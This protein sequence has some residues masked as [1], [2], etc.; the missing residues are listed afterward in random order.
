MQFKSLARWTCALLVAV[1]APAMAQQIPITDFAKRSEAWGATLSPTGEYAAIEVPTADGQETQLQIV[2]LDGSGKTQVL[3][4]GK[5][6]HVSD[7]TWT[8]DDRVVVARAKLEPLMARPYSTGQLMT[9]DINGK[10]QD[11]LFGYVPDAGLVRG[12]RK[13]E[14]WADVIKVLD[15]QPGMALVDFTCATCGKEPDTVIFRVDTRTGERKEVER[16]DKLAWYQFDR[17]GEARIRRTLDDNDEPV[18]SYRRT[19]GAAW[20]PMPKS[21]AGR[22][23]WNSRWEADNNTLYA[24]VTDGL[25]PEQ[26][27]RIDLAAGTRTKLAGRPDAEVANWMIEGR[28]GVPFAVYFNTDKPSIQY[29]KMDSE[30]AKLH[31]GLMKSFPG[32]IVWFNDVSRDGNKVLF[33]VSSDR[34]PGDWYLYDRA[35]KK[36]Q[37]LVEFRPW[38]KPETMATTRPISFTTRDGTQLFGLYTSKGNGPMPTVVMPHGGPYGVADEWGFD[39]EVQFLASRGYAVLQINYR[40]SSG[41]G[42]AFE[43]SGWLGWGDKIQNDITDG[44][45]YAIDNKLVDPNRVCMFGASFGG[46]SALMQPIVNPGT[47]KCAIGYVG[48]YDLPLMRKTDGNQGESDRST[49]FWKRTLGTDT[50]ALAKISPALRAKEIGV[51]VMLVHGKADNTA[52]LNQFKAMSAALREAGHP[53]EEFLA[54][55]EGHGFAKPENIAELYTRME[56]FLDKYIGPGAQTAATGK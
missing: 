12:K 55:G 27:Y 29:I 51:P 38:V 3:R 25:E 17:T 26:A 43:R 22:M 33:S 46:Y 45:K 2:K 16:G 8:A 37:K 4:F 35:A 23:L 11:V 21:I 24:F 48:V 30:W 49:R 5:M 34:S 20:E 14:G 50:A 52:D 9:A 54:A 6:E 40:G 19:K 7:V 56:K 31:A 42:L 32:N 44:L 28:D 53:A 15:D 10:N 47:Y 36:A 41:R 39:S 13:D 1:A 18:M